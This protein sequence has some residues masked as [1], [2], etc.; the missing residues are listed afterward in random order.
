MYWGESMLE[1][2]SDLWGK[3]LS[4]KL[5]Y[6]KARR[7]PISLT[8][9]W[10]FEFEMSFTESFL[11]L[12]QLIEISLSAS[13]W[14]QSWWYVVAAQF[15]FQWLNK[16]ISTL[17]LFW[18]SQIAGYWATSDNAFS[19]VFFLGSNSMFLFIFHKKNFEK[20]SKFCTNWQFFCLIQMIN[21]S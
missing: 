14:T 3:Q 17:D 6:R 18:W 16:H 10:K 9:S 4:T 19:C 11:K 1:D 13:F 21:S 20:K 8:L 15:K 7:W 2:L 5:I 12:N